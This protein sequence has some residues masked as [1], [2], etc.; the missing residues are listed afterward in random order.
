M[1]QRNRYFVVELDLES[2][3]GL[4]MALRFRN[5]FGIP[6]RGAGA[7]VRDTSKKRPRIRD[8]SKKQP[9]V[10]INEVAAKLGAKLVGCLGMVMS[11]RVNN[12]SLILEIAARR[13][14]E[15]E[16]GYLVFLSQR[17]DETFVFEEKDIIKISQGDIIL[18]QRGQEKK[19]GQ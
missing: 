8:T 18:W 2:Q 7:R 17:P 11:F 9:K 19:D 16:G 3:K 5:P 1:A 13:F 15:R 6:F 12:S 10:D 4:L 14:E